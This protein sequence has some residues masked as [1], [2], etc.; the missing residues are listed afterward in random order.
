MHLKSGNVQD[1][2][3]SRK[4]GQNLS[5][6][7]VESRLPDIFAHLDDGQFYDRGRYHSNAKDIEQTFSYLSKNLNTYRHLLL[8]AHGGLN[9]PKASASRI[10][11]MK[12]TFKR[13]GIYPFHFMYDTGLM[14]ELKDVVMGKS[15]ESEERV[16]GF[17]DFTDT[18]IETLAAR[19]GTAIWSEMKRGAEQSFTIRGHGT[20]ILNTIQNCLSGQ[21][22]NIEIH[23]V[24]HSLGS[25]FMGHLLDRVSSL[26][27]WPF[28]IK[29]VTLLAPACNTNFYKDKYLRHLASG[30]AA[31][32]QIGS[33]AMYCLNDERERN[34][35]VTPAYRKSLLYLV[36][37]AFEQ[38][39]SS[40]ILGMQIFQN[41][42]DLSRAKE[43]AYAG[44]GELSITDSRTHGGFDNDMATMNRIFATYS[45][46]RT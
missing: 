5:P 2:T 41:D 35:T 9:S 22:K 1:L 11:A 19:L 32:G 14:E 26:K 15:N 30:S 39:G 25:I 4:A 7:H 8:Y 29:S 10:A 20:T 38:V 28:I 13:N 16:G 18:I 33:F 46:P 21:E 3:S 27:D 23:L 31:P 42:A 43:V 6:H 36:S 24:G 34:D 45:Q 17:S 37:N 12:N 44:D 40:S